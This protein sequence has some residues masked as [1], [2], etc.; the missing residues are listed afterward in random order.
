MCKK[1]M[2]GLLCLLLGACVQSGGEGFVPP[3]RDAQ[4]CMSLS[5]AQEVLASQQDQLLQSLQILEENI[6]RQSKV[7][8]RQANYLDSLMLA[9][10]DLEGSQASRG[11]NQS[12]EQLPS[13]YAG[14]LVVGAIENILLPET[15]FVVAARVDTGA[16][17]SSLDARNIQNF[18]RNGASWVRFILIDPETG[19][20]LE[21]ERRRTRL[22][23]IIQSTDDDGEVRPVVELR[24]T[25]G[26][27]TQVSEFTL[28]DRSHLRQPMLL[29]RNV[30]R[31]VMLVDVSSQNLVP[32]VLEDTG[33]QDEESVEL[34]EGDTE[35]LQNGDDTSDAGDEA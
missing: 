1:M 11:D 22:V 32:L 28:T 29:G 6:E 16:N 8:Q 27:R 20:E 2:T 13:T 33:A 17:T 14:K 21:M 24:I 10:C 23:R 34:D 26:D 9:S 18:E 15:G 4:S 7:N 19:D 35:N 30:L 31:D 12:A 25:L 3:V 5:Q